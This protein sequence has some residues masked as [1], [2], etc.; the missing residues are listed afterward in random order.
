MFAVAEAITVAEDD[1]DAFAA[2]AKVYE[3]V[4][5]GKHNPFA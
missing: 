1:T 4:G 5:E 2:F 3:E